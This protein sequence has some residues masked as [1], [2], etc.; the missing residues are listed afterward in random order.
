MVSTLNASNE[1]TFRGRVIDAESGLPMAATVSVF[2]GQG[3]TVNLD[4]KYDHVFYLGKKRWYV[5]GEFSITTDADSLFIEI[6][7][8]LETYPINEIIY[9]SDEMQEVRE[10]KL[11]RWIN[12]VDK[13]FLSGDSHVHFM[14]T[15]DAYSQMQAEDLHVVNLLTSDFTND[16]ELFTGTLDEVSTEEHFVYVGQELRDWQMGH[17]N[18]LKLKYIVQPL[19]PFGGTLFSM[20]SN[21]NLVMSPRLEEARGQG[22][23]TVWAHFSNLPGLE[24]AIAFPLGLIDAVELM[25]YDD[26][27]QLPSHWA[28]WDYTELSQVEFPTLRGMDL[29][30]QYLNAGFQLP[31]TAGTDK[32]GDNIPVGSNRHYVRLDGEV[33][34]ENWIEGLKSGRGF[35]TNGPMLNLTVDEHLSGASINYSGEKTIRVKVKAEPLLPFGRVEIMANGKLIAWEYLADYRKKKDLYTAELETEITLNESTWIAGRVT[36][37]DTP[38]MLPRNLTVFA[39]SNPVYMLK[40]QQP[41]HVSASVEYLLDYLKSSRNWIENY[42]SFKDKA[43]KRGSDEVPEKS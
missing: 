41:V 33:S 4:G 40:D 29:Y 27:T 14:G 8:G 31:I 36:S 7:H 23:A 35:V 3:L 19:D 1:G 42:S 25:T 5:N 37:L 11:Q 21:P 17:V 34:F 2:D 6:R 26:P 30:Y 9:L 38:Q 39:H 12:M 28:P 16:V 18:L 24:S 20:G 43:E 13:G 10:F 32:M 22:A 15:E